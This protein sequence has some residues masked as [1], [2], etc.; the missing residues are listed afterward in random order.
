MKYLALLLLAVWLGASPSSARAEISSAHQQEA[1]S[2]FEALDALV[3]QTREQGDL[4]RWSNPAHAQVLA[5]LWNV[6]ATLGSPPYLASDM[7]ALF[8]IAEKAGAVFKTYLLFSPK[9][10]IAPDTAANSAEY[11]DEITRAAAYMTKVFAVQLEATSDFVATLPPAQMNGSRREGLRRVRLGIMEQVSGFTLMLRSP[12]LRSEN[13]ILLLDAL[14]G[15]SGPLTK[16]IS[17]ADRAAM[18]AQIDA[19][20]PS[21]SEAE[22]DKALTLKAA[23]ASQDCTGLCALER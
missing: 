5:R 17:L 23:F 4:P 8:T 9:S 20:L 1:A 3:R 6:E 10:D 11:Q 14:N 15:S 19:A 12:G 21:L 22:R 18:M 7:P 13:R 2:A 16:A